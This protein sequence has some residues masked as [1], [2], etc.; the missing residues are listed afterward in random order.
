M[1]ASPDVQPGTPRLV[2]V[3]AWGF[4]IGSALFVAGV[5]LSTS[6]LPPA[7]SGWTFFAGSVFFTT[8]AVLQTLVA[9]RELSDDLVR[10]RRWNRLMNPRAT[11]WTA[12]AVQLVGTLEFNVTTL[13]SALV[14]AGAAD[15]SAQ[16]VWRPD[17]IGSVL[18]LVSSAIALAPEVRHRR[19]THVRNRSWAVAA[20]NMLGS[21]LFGI[22][23]IG[24]RPE[25]DGVRNLLWANAGTVLGAL[26][27]LVAA[28]LLLPRRRST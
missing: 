27:F 19:H 12:A 16:Q 9:R 8:A 14:L 10:E 22:S 7:V 4:M 3:L 13:A 25:G 21:I 11:D 2:P 26:C 18:F 17:A 5:P 24:A 1:T 20:L 15:A 28:A 6:D 23:A